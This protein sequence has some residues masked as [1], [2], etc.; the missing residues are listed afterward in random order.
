MDRRE[1][2]HAPSLTAADSW[3]APAT[4]VRHGTSRDRASRF[5]GDP[6][7]L[8][9]RV[10]ATCA[11]AERKDIESANR[12][13]LQEL[14]AQRGALELVEGS[15][16]RT[17]PRDSD[18]ENLRERL[19]RRETAASRSLPSARAA[20]HDEA[21]APDYRRVHR[22]RTALE[23]TPQSSVYKSRRSLLRDRR[24]GGRDRGARRWAPTASPGSTARIA[25]VRAPVASSGS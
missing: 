15:S 3:P 17:H 11:E 16:D 8:D 24:A 18:R 22:N 23:I 20:P 25:G 12:R 21:K 10:H 1:A 2:A 19:P 9:A 4:R 5:T 14:A 13:I 6:T 7:L